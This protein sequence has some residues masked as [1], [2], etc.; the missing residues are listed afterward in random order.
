MVLSGG[1]VWS[2][3]LT[4]NCDLILANIG[5]SLALQQ[6]FNDAFFY[7]GKKLYLQ[8]VKPFKYMIERLDPI[9]SIIFG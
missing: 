7:T 2:V 9:F 4:T 1:Y 6:Y 5:P 8:V 3:L